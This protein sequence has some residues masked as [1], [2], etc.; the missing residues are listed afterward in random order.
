[1]DLQTSTKP[2]A[3]YVVPLRDLT[4]A[5]VSRVGAKAANLGE[6]L[7]AG[8]PVP[9][10]F[11]LT[12]QAFDRFV[13]VNMLS[14]TNSP[15]QVAVAPLPPDVADALRAA[16]TPLDGT[17]L[18]VRSSGVAEDL[19]GASFAGQYETI[20][21]VHGYDALA[22]AVRQCWASAFSARVAAYKSN[23]GQATNADMAVLVQRLIPADA[24]GV[25]FTA[26]PVNGNRNQ[27]VVSAVRGLGERL[28]S[29]NASP[30][31]W[32]VSGQEA[33][34]TSAPEN[35]INAAQAREV[36]EMARRAA[37]HFGS[38]QDVEWAIADG[39]LFMLQ[40]RPITT[41]REQAIEPIPMKIE[42]PPGY[43]ES[44]AEHIP[45]PLSPMGR[46]VLLP[47][48][49]NGTQKMC[50]TTG[51][52]LD[53]VEYRD[54]GGWIYMRL[55]PPG[56]KDMD[57]PP[58]W[59]MKI[60][61]RLIPDLRARIRRGT[62]FVRNNESD[63]LV[64]RWY[65]KWYPEISKE[66]RELRDVNLAVL[67][68][69]ELD[70]HM[71]RALALIGRGNE[72]HFTL[73]AVNPF[74][75]YDLVTTSQ[76]LLGW[77]EAHVMELVTGL[78]AKSTEPSRKLAELAQ[79][80]RTRPAVRELIEHANANTADRLAQVDAEFA[81]AFATYLKEYGCRG[82][83]FDLN[84]PT[85][86]ESPGLVLGWI[87][88]QIARNY[89]PTAD[90]AEL[91]KKRNAAQA[92]ARAT[93][94][95]RSPQERERFERA[96]ARAIRGYPSQ[97]DNVFFT[98]GAPTAL[99]RYALLELGH[100]LAKKQVIESRDDVF[101]LE[102]EEARAEFKQGGDLKALVLRRK[103]ER[104]WAEQ[105]PGPATYGNQPAQPSL[106]VLPPEP[107]FLMS[108]VPW[109]M[110]RAVSSGRG[111]VQK[112]GATLTGIAASPGTYQGTVRVVMN[113]GEFHKLQPGDVLVCPATT[114]VWSVLFSNV[115]ALVTNTGGILS[116]PA[117]IA[118]EYRVPAVV[119]TG[120]AT[121][122][123]H[124]GQMVM[125]DGNSGQVEIVA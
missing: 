18:A 44:D 10:G 120:N 113:E 25:A 84:E 74:A 57:P 107:R 13:N 121:A 109:Y 15:E 115:G 106:D 30:D 61:L 110:E 7:H 31:E 73:A 36:A 90:A 118:R 35:A 78:S 38:P 63:V 22:D 76:A 14:E 50:T 94:A 21:G 41:L 1:M 39:K 92:E 122:L 53:R 83:A 24:A 99:G 45:K 52:L 28:V 55:V 97:E 47:S 26:N 79:M 91:D 5:D 11:A 19:A 104:V 124:D 69:A 116:H 29:G 4:R 43:W 114:P 56:G 70:T 67:S 105:H 98:Q 23:Q 125:V 34:R 49:T 40:A 48:Y 16:V 123:L 46:S 112:A 6:L 62:E 93:L 72:V 101:F 102:I 33:T 85:I 119:A 12:T 117:I 81:E 89:D 32:I 59:V 20:L 71:D 66:M 111:R 95:N 3:A 88:D 54:I 68:D 87:R 60:M 37:A 82:L 17:Q 77:D 51:F 58:T 64:E 2:D 65:D 75:I 80:A 8:F 108:V 100:R 42:V 86:A 96:L 9:D 103:G 27:A